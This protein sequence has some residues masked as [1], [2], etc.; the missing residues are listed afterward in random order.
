MKTSR[1]N[2]L[3]QTSALGSGI[4][5]SS[6]IGT[7]IS[8]NSASAEGRLTI[9]TVRQDLNGQV[10]RGRTSGVATY[11]VNQG[12]RHLIPDEL[13]FNNLF[14]NWGIIITYDDLAF[15]DKGPDLT[16]GAVLVRGNGVATWLITNGQKMPINSEEIMSRYHFDYQKIAYVPQVLLDAATVGPPV[17]P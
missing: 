15:I 3:I 2:L 12:T 4:V 10:V 13:T 14:T 8:A 7:V 11:L 9:M 6:L 1:R 17:G 5:A 16:S